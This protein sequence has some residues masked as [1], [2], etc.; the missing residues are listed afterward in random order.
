MLKDNLNATNKYML[1]VAKHNVRI[2]VILN[3]VQY[4]RIVQ[5]ISNILIVVK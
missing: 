2:K 1:V 4:P 5:A 3:I